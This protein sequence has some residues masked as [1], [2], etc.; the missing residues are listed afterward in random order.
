MYFAPKTLKSA[1]GLVWEGAKLPSSRSTPDQR[2]CL[3]CSKTSVLFIV[4]EWVTCFW[5]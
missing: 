1:Q 4:S 5:S 2:Q 3:A